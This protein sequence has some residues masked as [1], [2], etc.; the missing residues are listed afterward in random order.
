MTTFQYNGIIGCFA[1]KLLKGEL[2]QNNIPI[3]Q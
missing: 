3:K 2:V 1:T